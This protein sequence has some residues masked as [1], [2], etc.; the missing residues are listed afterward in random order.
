MEGL[1]AFKPEKAARVCVQKYTTTSR[2]GGVR[3]TVA[4]VEGV[5][6]FIPQVDGLRLYGS[7]VEIPAPA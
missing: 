3:L 5:G 2:T 4:A 1:P 6:R 7:G